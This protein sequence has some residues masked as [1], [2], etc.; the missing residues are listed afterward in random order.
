MW[1]LFAGNTGN[2]DFENYNVYYSYYS[3]HIFDGFWFP[4]LEKGFSLLMQIANYFG[5]SYNQF[6]GIYAFIGLS[7]IANSILKYSKL[8]FLPLFLYFFYQYFLDI[9]QIRNFMLLSIFIF[10]IRYLVDWY[11]TNK[12]A[13]LLKYIACILIAVQ[14]QITGLFFLLAVFVKKISN[15]R[16]AKRITLVTVLLFAFSPYILKIAITVFNDSRYIIYFNNSTSVKGVLFIV[17]YIFSGVLI[18]NCLN[19][20]I[21]GDQEKG[22]G[23][24]LFSN[25]VL[26]FNILLITSIFLFSITPDFIRIYRNVQVLNYIMLT[27]CMKPTKISL[28]PRNFLS[29]TSF[30]LF[31]I[32]SAY[33][34]LWLQNVNGVILPILSNNMFFNFIKINN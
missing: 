34:F 1:A 7:L 24:S 25:V 28:K 33:S 17:F 12:M 8:K 21:Q 3:M 6:L 19:N 5:L 15:I 30:I 31:F 32:L 13:S 26:K 29:S 14:F 2:A 23:A 20:R 9:V 18:I 27:H 22:V 16:L 10:S 4:D 11:N